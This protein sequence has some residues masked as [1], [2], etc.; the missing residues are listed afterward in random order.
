MA[1]ARFK[2]LCVDVTDEERMASFWS[3]ATGLRIDAEDSG[4]LVG[5]TPAHTIWL[6]VVA[7]PKSVKQRVHLDVSARSVSDIAALGAQQVSAD[8]E[9]DWTVMTDPEG[10]ELCVFVRDEVPD[11]RLY[12]IGVDAVNPT[13]S[14]AW[15]ADVL[16]AN[17]VHDAH[18]CS[19]VDQIP[20]APFDSMDFVP[21]PEP[22]TVKNRLHW[23]VTVRAY[24]DIDLLVVR[25]ASV[26][27]GVD[28]DIEWTVM[29]D[30][31][32]NEFCVFVVAD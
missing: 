13:A 3:A 4:K 20:N 5:E 24:A 10:G 2:D 26:V 28:D 1:I 23:D 6:N 29:A 9:F 19:F 16:D 25:G 7:E 27:R 11:Y 18:G 22:K 32:G 12:E 17:L 31:E 30:P 21:V 15:W 14:A 8:G